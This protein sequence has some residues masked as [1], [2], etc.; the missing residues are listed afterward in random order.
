MKRVVLG[1]SVWALSLVLWGISAPAHIKD[2]NFIQDGK[3]SFLVGPVHDWHEYQVGDRTGPWSSNRAYREMPDSAMLKSF[4]MNA[5]QPQALMSYFMMKEHFPEALVLRTWMGFPD[6]FKG[7]E[8][9]SREKLGRLSEMNLTLDFGDMGLFQGV[10]PW[11]KKNGRA[12]TFQ[13]NGWWHDFLPF[14]PSFPEAMAYYKT[15]YREGTRFVLSNGGAPVLYELG[16]EVFY[17]SF[18]EP[19][20]T[21]FVPWLEKR[22]GNVGAA[23]RAWGTAF[24]DFSQVGPRVAG[25]NQ[26]E[27]GPWYDWMVF[28]S[29]RVAGHFKEFRAAVLEV[30]RRPG[31]KAF[32]VQPHHQVFSFNFANAINHVA[33][34]FLEAE[35]TEYTGLTFS[36][37][38]EGP[39]FDGKDMMA[40]G[41][42]VGNRES[43]LGAALGKAYARGR[44]LVDNETRTVR[45]ENGVRV[46]SWD[47]DIYTTLWHQVMFDY[48]QS[49]LYTWG[50]RE[51][52]WKTMAEAKKSAQ[53]EGYKEG[54]L[55]NPYNYPEKSLMGVKRFRDTM[56]KI[57]DVVLPK[58]RVVG[59]VG[60]LYLDHQSWQLIGRE[61]KAPAAYFAAL[62]GLQIPCDFVI[63]EYLKGSED[64]ARFEAVVC[65]VAEYVPLVT[66]DILKSYVAKGGTL[67]CAP[68]SFT[69]D[70]YGQATSPQDLLGLRFEKEEAPFV[71]R[72]S[73]MGEAIG[74]RYDSAV[75][76]KQNGAKPFAPWAEHKGALVWKYAL[77]RGQVYT[78]TCSRGDQELFGV[79]GAIAK[80]RGINPGV[81]FLKDGQVDLQCTADLIDRGEVKII[82]LVNWTYLSKWG[83]LQMDGLAEGEWSLTF[84]DSGLQVTAASTKETFSPLDFS[85]GLGCYLPAQESVLLYLSKKIPPWKTGVITLGT[86]SNQAAAGLATDTQRLQAITDRKRA[87]AYA[88]VES[89]TFKGLSATN[90]FAVD[91]THHVNMGFADE[92]PNDGVGGASDQGPVNDLSALL[93]SV[94]RTTFYGVP[95]QIIDPDKN[96]GRS[97]CVLKGG[98]RIHF[99]MAVKGIAVGRA[100]DEIYFLQACAWTS[101]GL[102]W[103]YLVKYEDGGT[104]EVPVEKGNACL[105]WWGPRDNNL[106]SPNARIAWTGRNKGG[107]E[108]G[109]YSFRWKN[110]SPEKKVQGIDILSEG[111]AVPMVVAMTGVPAGMAPRDLSG[112]SLSFLKEKLAPGYEAVVFGGD[113]P[114]FEEGPGGLAEFTSKTRPGQWGGFRFVAR[115]EQGIELGEGNWAMTFEVNYT[116]GDGFGKVVDV[117]RMQLKVITTASEK[118]KE[119]PLSP[120]IDTDGQTWETRSVAV[121]PGPCR[122]KEIFFQYVNN[123]PAE[124][125]R[126]RNVRFEPDP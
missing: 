95:Y 86:L 30:D 48:S 19:N 14:D 10:G 78:L 47:Q 42:T 81:K 23:N 28:Q 15:M 36:P 8:Q 99:P 68:L 39:Q 12:A 49:I 63:A 38:G 110:P 123:N 43:I 121:G 100:V 46:P 9:A 72:A 54:Y 87:A 52:E 65:P 13:K 75:A 34:S 94:G 50:N 126:I 58:P 17:N 106:L 92:T 122:V 89:R 73:V 117:P 84:A 45:M 79:L 5:W 105:D 31:P 107:N 20:L 90:T 1:I 26:K 85:K 69:R 55:L 57:A 11:A 116:G 32:T 40:A 111:K 77:G 104:L 16:N 64:L 125:A 115:G 103:K 124:G 59:R 7:L 61:A 3:P 56:E 97:M 37:S 33:L 22:H 25:A 2:G 35:C 27:P 66:K 70:E 24:S 60:V 80:D 83:S 18:S 96:D 118:V 119:K 71:D 109:L 98:D 114:S 108:I 41:F 91:L 76:V 74:G 102:L 82:H 6:Y 53:S 51:W 67:I 112:A 120:A 29:E 88:V 93:P 62:R 21:A 4:G 44:L 113:S 101:S